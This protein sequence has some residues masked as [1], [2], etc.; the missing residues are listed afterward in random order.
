[1]I[2]MATA[3][4]TI[5]VATRPTRPEPRQPADTSLLRDQELAGLV[6]ALALGAGRMPLFP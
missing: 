6:W 4:D 1:V 5:E 2:P 3:T